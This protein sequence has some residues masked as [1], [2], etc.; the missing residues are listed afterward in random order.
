MLETNRSV[1]VFEVV[2][3]L[4][5]WV[6]KCRG[7]W[8]TP[9]SIRNNVDDVLTHGAMGEYDLLRCH[10]LR[11]LMASAQ[12]FIDCHYPSL[13]Y[14][15]SIMFVIL[16]NIRICFTYT[17]SR[18]INPSQSGVTFKT[19]AKYHVFRISIFMQQKFR[20]FQT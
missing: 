16:N 18:H 8:S 17:F 19:I 3:D 13:W 1:D 7:L 4:Q 9:L 2:V 20:Q 10:K 15:I 12:E 14:G 5:I 11:A 6:P